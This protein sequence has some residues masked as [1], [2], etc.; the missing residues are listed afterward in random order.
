MVALE[1]KIFMIGN[2]TKTLIKKKDINMFI[3]NIRLD[4]I[5]SFDDDFDQEWFNCAVTEKSLKSEKTLINYIKKQ[6]ENPMESLYKISLCWNCDEDMVDK[7]K[8]IKESV[9]KN[10]KYFFEKGKLDV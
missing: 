2:N 3:K 7:Y 4:V 9:N 5:A 8:T 1:R 6:L 10:A